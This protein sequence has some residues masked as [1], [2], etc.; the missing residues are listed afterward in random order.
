MFL[1]MLVRKENMSCDEKEVLEKSDYV[2]SL[3]KP[4]FDVDSKNVLFIDDLKNV[5]F[6]DGLFVLTISPFLLMTKHN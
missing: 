5:L 1:A 2:L 6:T 3:I 4:W